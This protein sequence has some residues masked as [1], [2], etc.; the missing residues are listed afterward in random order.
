MYKNYKYKF[1]AKYIYICTYFIILFIMKLL[2]VSFYCTITKIKN[3]YRN[4]NNN[5]LKNKINSNRLWFKIIY[6]FNS[7]ILIKTSYKKI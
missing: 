2:Y 4:Q 1:T 7:G 5:S 3:K 6:Q